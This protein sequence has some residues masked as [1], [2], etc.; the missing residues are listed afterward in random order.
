MK[1]GIK[2]GWREDA[3]FEC[4]N[5]LDRVLFVCFAAFRLRDGR[6]G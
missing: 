2:D 4:H 3:M 6:P 5:A 1:E